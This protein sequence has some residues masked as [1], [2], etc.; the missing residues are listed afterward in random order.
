MGQAS[1]SLAFPCAHTAFGQPVSDHYTRVLPRL[2]P[3]EDRNRHVEKAQAE[4]TL[5]AGM[6]QLLKGKQP[7]C[8]MTR[9]S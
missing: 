9:Y 6:W 1:G 3:R 2:K 8:R 4:R 7:R 5:S